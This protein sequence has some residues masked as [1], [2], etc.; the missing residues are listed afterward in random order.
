MSDIPES[1]SFQNE[2]NSSQEI[3]HFD[4]MAVLSEQEEKNVVQ[5]LN[6]IEESLDGQSYFLGEVPQS[7]LVD[8]QGFLPLNSDRIIGS[9][10]AIE[11]LIN[12]VGL[13]IHDEVAKIQNFQKKINFWEDR[14]EKNKTAIAS[15]ESKMKQNNIDMVFDKK[16]RDYWTGRAEQVA[17]DY[18]YASAADRTEDWAWLIKK[19]GLKNADSSPIDSDQNA[20]EE[21][22]NGA[23]N[24]LIGEYK[25][26][27]NKYEQAR[28]DRELENHRLIHENSHLKGSNETLKGYISATYTKEIE[29]LQE[30]VLLLKELSAKL[31]SMSQDSHSTFGELRAWAEPFINDFIKMNSRGPQSIVTEFRKFASIPLPAQ[32]S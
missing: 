30:G 10:N 15:S 4:P 18:S 1:S 14:I 20:I 26:A 17:I 24:N 8:P 19:Y 6:Q 27:S 28:R 16:N 31:Q 12:D 2:E 21:L 5:S 29:P 13:L 32:N 11:P 23:S 9:T 22:C 7:Y 25:N 3:S